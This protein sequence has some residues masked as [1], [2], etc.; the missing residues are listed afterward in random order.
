[1]YNFNNINISFSVC[2]KQKIYFNNEQIGVK[3]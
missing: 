1:M 2:N 3:I